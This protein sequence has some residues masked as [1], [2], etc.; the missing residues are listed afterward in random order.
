MKAS[1]A[2]HAGEAPGWAVDVSLNTTHNAIRH[3]TR[4]ATP[5]EP[6]KNHSGTAAASM[7]RLVAEMDEV[8][9]V[10]G[11]QRVEGAQGARSGEKAQA[12]QTGEAANA[13]ETMKAAQAAHAGQASGSAMDFLPNTTQNATQNSTGNATLAKS[14]K[15]NSGAAEESMFRGV[16]SA[17]IDGVDEEFGA[18]LAAEMQNSSGASAKSKGNEVRLVN[19]NSQQVHEDTGKAKSNSTKS[20]STKSNSTKSNSTD[21]YDPLLFA[22]KP[23]SWRNRSKE[24]QIF[25]GV[26]IGIRNGASAEP[27]MFRGVAAD[28]R[29]GVEAA[30]HGDRPFDPWSS[31]A[32][33]QSHNHTHNE[34]VFLPLPGPSH[35]AVVAMHWTLV[36]AFA[37]VLWRLAKR[38]CIR[39]ESDAEGGQDDPFVAMWHRCSLW[40]ENHGSYSHVGGER[41]GASADGSA[42]DTGVSSTFVLART[43]SKRSLYVV[44]L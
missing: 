42:M 6:Q 44:Q 5:A 34:G 17:E 9:A 36:V 43:P 24:S 1:Q 4:N 37:F 39:R 35:A 30:K 7:F 31:R 22:V 3:A 41:E 27:Q 14:Q 13:T 8:A 10:R 19:S 29:T 20:N 18:A 40:G 16:V 25:S 11:H 2:A 28:I 23:Q 12:M 21:S 26:V 38:Y 33:A 32:A 15:N